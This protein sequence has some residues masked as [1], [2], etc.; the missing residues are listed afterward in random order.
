MPSKLMLPAGA[1][2]S[3]LHFPEDVD[4][5]FVDSDMY[6]ISERVSEISPDIHIW[7]LARETPEGA[8]FGYTLTESCV[9]GVERLIFKVK[10]LDARVVNRLKE[11]FSV[12]L[13]ERIE[14]LERE[15]WRFEQDQK[16][17]EF[18]ELYEKLGRPMWT[19][20]E[21]D[22]FIQRPVSYPKLGVI[23]KGKRAR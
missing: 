18:E 8:E 14:K 7:K 16:E 19:Q 17:Q 11:L 22:G 13:E 21:H 12:P 6:G 10:E 1:V 9:D 15:N 23:S 4:V 20:M 5:Q 3:N 2:P